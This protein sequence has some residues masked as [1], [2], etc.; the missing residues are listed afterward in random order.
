[1]LCTLSLLLVQSLL[2]TTQLSSQ[3]LLVSLQTLHRLLVAF[4][5]ALLLLSST[6]D[7]LVLFQL[8]DLFQVLSYVVLIHAVVILE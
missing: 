5:F 6:L 7:S 4:Q 3:C 2:L 8:V 1:M